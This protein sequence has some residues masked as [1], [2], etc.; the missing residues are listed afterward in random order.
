MLAV[1]SAAT[2]QDWTNLGGNAARN[3]QAAVLGPTQADLL[4]SAPGF[5]IIAWHPVIEGDRVFVI[6][7]SGFPQNGGPP[8][9]ILV[10]YDLHTGAVLWDEVLPFGGD[11]SVEWIAWIAGVSNGQVYASRASHSQPQP[12]RA[13]DAATGAFLWESAYATQAFAYD[14]VVFADNGDPIVGDFNSVVRISAVDGST[15]W[16]V[17]RSCAVSGNCGAA[18]SD[19]GVLIDDIAP[20]GNIVRKLD[21]NSGATLYDSPVMAGFTNQN[22]PFASPDGSTVYFSRT[23]NNVSVDFLFAFEDTGISLVEKWN[24]PVRWTT[25]H[26]HGIG[27]DGSIYTFTQADEFV[28]LD[29]DTGDIIG[30]AGVLSPLGS[31]NLSAKTAIDGEGNVYVSN[32]WASTPATNGRLWAFSADLTQSLFTLNLDRQ[33]QGGPALGTD[34]TLVVA[35]RAGVFAYR[36]PVPSC[37]GDVDGDGDT[38]FDDLV[39]LLGDYGC[40]AGCVADLDGDGDTDFDDLIVLLGDYGCN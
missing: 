30:N 9:D 2:A 32:G 16:N 27:P 11:T 17:P 40:L 35:D 1:L 8:N 15:V 25:S 22:S 14:G 31:P 39:G 21:P 18:L 5:S 19:S 12:I 6:R 3:G 37:A 13:Y 20:G 34:G 23:Q 10:C 4:W 28:R 7:E 26:E 38:D 36:G 24:R 29:P 33:N